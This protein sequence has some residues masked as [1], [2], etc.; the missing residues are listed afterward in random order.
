[1]GEMNIERWEFENNVGVGKPEA[2][3]LIT[4]DWDAWKRWALTHGVKTGE[5]NKTIGATLIGG[6]FFLCPEN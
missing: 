3:G 5:Q 1:M 4:I 2:V 6:P